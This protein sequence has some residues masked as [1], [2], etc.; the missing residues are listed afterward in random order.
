MVNSCTHV[1]MHVLCTQTIRR[2]TFF[3]LWG[4]IFSPFAIKQRRSK[5]KRYGATF[6]CMASR[7]LHIEITYSLDSDSLLQALRRVMARRGN[8]KI[9][10]SG[11]YTNFVG[12]ANELKKAYKETHNNRIQSFMES[13]GEH[14]VTWIRKPPA[15]SNIGGVWD[16]QIISAHAIMSSLLSMHRKSFDEESLLTLVPKTERILKSRT[17]TVGTISDHTG[18]LPLAPSNIL[19]MKSKALMPPPRSFSRSDLYCPKN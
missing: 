2:T 16:K 9:L 17:L 18:N 4:N 1:L 15:A 3:I 11:N 8:I 7:S 19:T 12:Y 14:I 5:I 6:T 13:F 10:Y